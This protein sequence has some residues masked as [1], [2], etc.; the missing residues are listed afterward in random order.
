MALLMSKP[1][2]RRGALR[3]LVT[4]AL[5]ALL[6]LG[7]LA[8]AVSADQV[9]DFDELKAAFVFQFAN[10]VQWP[11]SSFKEAS[12]P[13]VIGIVGN[14]AMVKTLSASVRGKMVGAHPI[15]VTS[16]GNEKAVAPCHI[17]YIDGSIDTRVDQYL[18]VT[19]SKPILTVSDHENFTSEGGVIRLFKKDNKLRFE[20]NVDEAQRAGLTI[21]SKLLGLAQVVHD[22]S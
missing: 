22:K 8:S 14:D 6:G 3:R 20:V 2:T 15:E 7:A 4:A 12:S 11:E 13:I 10:Y 17:L 1:T 16:V 21:S 19:R 9:V 18:A 5:A